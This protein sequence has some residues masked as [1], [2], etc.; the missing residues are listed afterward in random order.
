MKYPALFFFVLLLSCCGKSPGEEPESLVF[1][2]ETPKKVIVNGYNGDMME[3]FLSRDGR[4]L[5]FNNLN[6]PAVNTNIFYAVRIND[7]LFDFRGEVQG[8]N[9]P[10]L[11]GVPSMDKDSN[12]YFVSVANYIPT[13]ASIYKGQFSNGV[14]TNSSIVP[15]ISKQEQSWV[16]FDV[17]LSEDGS[18]LYFVDGKFSASWQI[19]SA[20]LVIAEK[21]TNG[22]RRMAASGEILK[23]INTEEL[24]YAACISPDELSFYFTRMPSVTAGILPR[25]WYATRTDK[26]KPFNEPRMIT[27]LDGFIEAATVSGDSLVYFHKRDNQLFGLYCL[28]KK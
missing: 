5:F 1:E 3:P 21:T 27:G 6:D 13:L 2:F 28:R 11:D 9:S 8:V 22:F 20:D 18:H 17:E 15:G 25:L 12:F 19:E 26:T 10:V 14:V 4:Y 24:E 16:N 7:T 23:N